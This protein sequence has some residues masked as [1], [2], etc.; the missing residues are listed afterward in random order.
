[1]TDRHARLT[2][3]IVIATWIAATTMA[4]GRELRMVAPEIPPHFDKSGHGRIADVVREALE[5]CGHSVRFTLVPFGRHW[6]DYVDRGQFDGLATA[7]AD[8]TFPG[9]STKPFIDLHD[10]ATVRVDSGLASISAATE[11]EGRRIVAF[12]SADKI[13]GIES[14]VP[15][16]R[17]FEMRAERFDQLRPLFAGRADAVLA[18]GLITAHFVTALRERAQAGLEPD[19]DA[20]SR[21]AF[22]RIFASGPQR[23][24][25]K[26]REVA[27]D[28]DRCVAQLRQE[29]ALRRIAAPYVDK[30]KDI[31]GNQYPHD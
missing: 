1:M 17:S 28:F 12:P 14:L 24:Y 26:D 2:V 19:I 21:I 7:E 15:R 23:L 22:R 6:K 29:G 4:H 8:Q 30:F 9:H 18:D 3:A 13:L 16:F 27:T 11:L 10:G 25:F 5:R 31:L 20:D